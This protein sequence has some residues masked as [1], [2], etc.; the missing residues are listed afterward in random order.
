MGVFKQHRL[1]SAVLMENIP[2]LIIQLLYA[3]TIKGGIAQISAASAA[4]IFSSLLSIAAAIFEF[5][6]KRNLL[7][8]EVK[9][10]EWSTKVISND[11]KFIGGRDKFIHETKCIVKAIA[12]V[13]GFNVNAVEI[14]FIEKC[15]EDNGQDK[16]LKIHGLISS[17]SHSERD[18]V[19]IWTEK[20]RALLKAIEEAWELSVNSTVLSDLQTVD[21]QLL[22]MTTLR[23]TDHTP[24]DQSEPV[25][26]QQIAVTVSAETD[27]CAEEL[28]DGGATGALLLGQTRGVQSVVLDTVTEGRTGNVVRVLSVPDD[29]GDLPPSFY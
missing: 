28:F 22:S 9:R 10:C 8:A 11:S 16:G 23:N 5:I 25:G 24:L 20:Q 29:T 7:D 17:K 3:E 15:T 18:I 4:A 1:F 6:S 19:R 14:L 26:P 21:V 13:T 12:E 2:Q 27:Q